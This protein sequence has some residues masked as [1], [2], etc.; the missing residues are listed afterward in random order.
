MSFSYPS[1]GARMT[2]RNV[3]KIAGERRRQEAEHA[4][5]HRFS[6]A[7][8]LQSL[9][10]QSDANVSARRRSNQAAQLTAE[11]M[12]EESAAEQHALQ[13]RV[14]RERQQNEQLAHVM[15]KTKKHQEQ[16]E[17]EVQRICDASEELRELETLLKTAYMNKE[18]AVQQL[19]R[20]T[21][22]TIDKR[23]DVA[24]EQQM[25]YDRQR[26]IVDM[27]NRELA[28]RAE[29]FEGKHV[30]QSQMLQRQE[31][32]REAQGE[33]DMERAKIEQLMKQI[34]LE[35]AQE[36]AK[37]QVQ[38][39]QTRELIDRSQQ[40]RDHLARQRQDELRRQEEEVA[41]YRR[42]VEA[43]E[44]A[45]RAA[46][47]T[48]KAHEDAMFKVVEAEIQ[49]KRRQEEEIERLRDDLWEEEMLQ[50][51][52]QQEE[53]KFAAKVRAKDDMMTSNAMQMRLKQEL[54]ARQQ[55]D[56]DAF[57]DM[58]KKKFQSEARREMELAAFKRRQKDEY[59]D[60]IA[61]HNAL[62]QQMVYEELQR[63]RR[64]RE[65][66]EQEEQY[67]KQIIEQAR[68]RLLQE[69]AEVLQG[70]LPRAL[71]AA[72]AGAGGRPS[73]SSS[74]SSSRPSAFR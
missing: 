73:S 44:T 69:H 11:R 40:E 50:K 74:N 2:T 61:R 8:Q 28:K 16:R 10:N 67:K 42:R 34:E 57:N 52:R 46:T 55:A 30:L 70:Y 43:R 6:Q 13:Q 63:E 21:L 66:Q 60:E 26:A 1:G 31:L 20:E 29:A 71:G 9:A 53:E 19:E 41:E 5:L 37:R 58:L 64:E 49:A 72:A 32:R 56:E 45:A 47:E 62:K 65:L 4:A 24:I 17:R 33:A 39:G 68:Q 51:K 23:R 48:K 14:G 25:E 54:V 15:E 22:L 18:R 59:K 38:R 7:N 36:I 35:D 12:L 27:Q 3:E